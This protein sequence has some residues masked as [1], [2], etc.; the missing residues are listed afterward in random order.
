MGVALGAALFFPDFSTFELQTWN[1]QAAKEHHNF[2]SLYLLQVSGSE[3][4]ADRG[5]RQQPGK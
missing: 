5:S 4:T 3:I 2:S 1:K